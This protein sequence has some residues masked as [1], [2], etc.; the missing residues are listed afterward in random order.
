MPS[1]S[2]NNIVREVATTRTHNVHLPDELMLDG[3]TYS[4]SGVVVYQGDRR[5]K[6]GHYWAVVPHGV[7]TARKFYTYN[8]NRRWEASEEAWQ[9][10]RNGHVYLVMYRRGLNSF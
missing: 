1:G 4:F 6:F 2:S 3:V 7:G 9:N 5:G 10:P 8:D